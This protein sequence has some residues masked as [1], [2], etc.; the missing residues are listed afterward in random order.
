MSD[1]STNY[2]SR[3]R[4]GTIHRIHQPSFLSIGLF[5]LEICWDID[6]LRRVGKNGQKLKGNK[7]K[8]VVTRSQID[9]ACVRALPRIIDT[10]LT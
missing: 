4:K 7:R 10:S 6:Q 5:W 8:N 2:V 3:Q 1:H 9:D